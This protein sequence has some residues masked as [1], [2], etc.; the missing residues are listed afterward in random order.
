M[1]NTTESESP[2]ERLRSLQALLHKADLRF[3]TRCAEI[4][5]DRLQLQAQAQQY[6]SAGHP[7]PD[8]IREALEASESRETDLLDRYAQFMESTDARYHACL[9][10]ACLEL[11]KRAS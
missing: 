1:D 7:I 9:E 2:L 10:L 11:A 8:S 3:R 5:A 4:D 6:R